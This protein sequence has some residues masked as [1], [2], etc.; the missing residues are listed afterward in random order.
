ML[1][2][3]SLSKSYGN[4]KVLENITLSLEAGSSTAIVGPSG[5]GK[6][7]LL[8]MIGALDKPDNGEILFNGQSIAGMSEKEQSWFRNQNVGFVFQMHHLLPQCSVLENV[9]IPT[10][11]AKKASKKET[12]KRA[13]ELIERVGLSAHINKLPSQLSGGECQRTAFVRALINQPS[14]ILADEPTGSLDGG[15]AQVLSDLLLLLNKEQNTAL[16][17][18]THAMQLAKKMDAVWELVNGELKIKI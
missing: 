7:T 8:N 16:V 13:V 4:Q 10:L 5:T 17:V 2:I 3:K 6:T 18:V 15:T 11:N 1:K 12:E 9:L 14:I